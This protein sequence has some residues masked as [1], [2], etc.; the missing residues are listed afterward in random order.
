MNA[1]TSPLTARTLETLIR[2]ATAHAKSRLSPKVT[3]GDAKASEAILRFALYKEVLRRP[4]KKK[5]TPHGTGAGAGGDDG[6]G[7][8]DASGEEEEDEEE[9]AIPPVERMDMPQE[10]KEKEK[11]GGP[12]RQAQDPVW[13]GVSQDVEMGDGDAP[14]DPSAGAGISKERYASS[15]IWICS[16]GL[17]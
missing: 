9:E 4:R 5:H 14:V 7:S 16:T 10:A 11:E 1:Q 2:L 17:C 6:D 15:C 3:E 13:G 12:D 8:E